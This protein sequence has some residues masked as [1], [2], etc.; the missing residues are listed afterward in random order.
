MKAVVAAFNQEKALVGAF[1]VI[2]NLRMAFV[3][4]TITYLRQRIVVLWTLDKWLLC[5]LCWPPAQPD[6]VSST[7]AA[8]TTSASFRAPAAAKPQCATPQILYITP[9]YLPSASLALW[10][11]RYIRYSSLFFKGAFSC[12]WKLDG[13]QGYFAVKKW[14]NKDSGRTYAT[15]IVLQ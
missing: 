14:A 8:L 1:S 5:L 9:Y 12:A 3:W 4:S 15:N 2:T 11:L 7:A 6:T 13:H 10:P